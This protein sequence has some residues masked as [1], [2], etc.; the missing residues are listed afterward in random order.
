MFK[1]LILPRSQTNA[2]FRDRERQGS[3]DKG[4]LEDQSCAHTWKELVGGF[5]LFLFLGRYGFYLQRSESWRRRTELIGYCDKV[6]EAAMKE[7]RETM[8]N[9]PEDAVTLKKIQAALY[10]D[11]VKVCC[12]C[13]PI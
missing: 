13:L 6:V 12:F 2:Q 1:P 11:Q 3:A 9:Q 5:L 8:R 10:H 7:K 4:N